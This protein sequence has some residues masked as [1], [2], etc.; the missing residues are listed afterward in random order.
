VEKPGYDLLE[1][2][3]SEVSEENKHKGKEYL[4]SMGFISSPKAFEKDV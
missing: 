3:K 1:G 2:L 4:A